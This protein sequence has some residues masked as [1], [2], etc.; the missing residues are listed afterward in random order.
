MPVLGE[1]RS[2]VNDQVQ[3]VGIGFTVSSAAEYRC[4]PRDAARC[5]RVR[6]PGEA[7]DARRVIIM[8]KSSKTS[9]TRRLGLIPVIALALVVSLPSREV[10]ATVLFGLSGSVVL[11]SL[12]V[13]AARC[14]AAIRRHGEFCRNNSW[15]LLLGCHLRQHRW[16]KLKSTFIQRRWSYFT[17]GMWSTPNAVLATAS[18]LFGIVAP[19]V[20]VVGWAVA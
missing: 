5:R 7:D 17:R 11:W 15:G 2:D 10:P 8:A 1:L 19:L 12:F 20:S 18:A 9:S 6:S 16:P 4:N 13:A 14:G 3:V